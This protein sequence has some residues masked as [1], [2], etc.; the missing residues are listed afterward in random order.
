MIVLVM[1]IPKPVSIND[2]TKTEPFLNEQC[3]G[4]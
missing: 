4:W 1:P 3:E 2:V